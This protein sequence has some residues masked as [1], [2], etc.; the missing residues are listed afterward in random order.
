MALKEMVL[1]VVEVDLV[2][3]LEEVQVV[4]LEVDTGVV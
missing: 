1:A 3:V 4:G 2:V